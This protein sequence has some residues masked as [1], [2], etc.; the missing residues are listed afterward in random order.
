MSYLTRV[1]ITFVLFV[2]IRTALKTFLQVSRGK[3]G[4]NENPTPAPFFTAFRSA[5]VLSSLDCCTSDKNCINDDDFVLL[6][7]SDLRLVSPVISDPVPSK[8]L[9]NRDKS[10]YS[11][12][13]IWFEMS[14]IINSD[15]CTDQ[16]II[17]MFTEAEK[18]LVIYLSGWLAHNCGICSL[19]QDV[20]SK[21]L[22]V[23]IQPLGSSLDLF[24]ENNALHSRCPDA[25]IDEF[26]SSTTKEPR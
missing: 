19:C 1:I 24:K 16:S 6:K 26:Q 11:G 14:N 25:V 23:F 4:W 8:S 5:V 10:F 18:S 17:E 12:D 7:H 22:C 21:Q 9:A 13:E 20:L 2:L 15:I 3:N